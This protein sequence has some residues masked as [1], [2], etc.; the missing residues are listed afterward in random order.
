MAEGCEEWQDWMCVFT[1][2][3]NGFFC[4]WEL[5]ERK[6]QAIGLYRYFFRFSIEKLVPFTSDPFI[7]FIV[8]NY[9]SETKL[10]RIHQRSSLIKH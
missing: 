8:I 10:E 6:R 9:F 2:D 5:Q 4:G 1:N 7:M 3:F